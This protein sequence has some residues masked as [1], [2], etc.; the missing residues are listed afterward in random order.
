METSYGFSSKPYVCGPIPEMR[1]R[2]LRIFREVMGRLGERQLNTQETIKQLV[3][4][5]I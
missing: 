1:T 4:E 2:P 3:P 5:N